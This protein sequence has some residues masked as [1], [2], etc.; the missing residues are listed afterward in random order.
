[1]TRTLDKRMTELAM[2]TYP[3]WRALSVAVEEAYERWARAPRDQAAA[4]YLGYGAALDQEERS[5]LEY[6]LLAG[7]LSA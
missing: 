2:E 5:S 3:E 7:G 1:M 6:A 4:A